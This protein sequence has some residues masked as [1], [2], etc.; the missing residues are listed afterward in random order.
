MKTFLVLLLAAKLYG[1][2]SVDYISTFYYE[3]SVTIS[4]ENWKK[5]DLSVTITSIGG[6]IIFNDRLDTRK[7]DG[8]KYNLR[9]LDSG[10]YEIVLEN[11]DKKVVETVI[12]F[13]GK[14]AEK[15]AQVYYKPVI[16][17]VDNKLKVNFLSFDGSASIK[18]YDEAL[19]VY[20]ERFENANPM[21]K[22]FDL[23]RLEPGKYTAV[24]GDG[25]TSR[26]VEF[27]K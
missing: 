27:E 13:D 8:I 9:N 11:N 18:I 3:P 10:K 21:N 26:T 16:E 12:L 17:M 23:S 20:A 1:N 2:V 4:F 14:I 25:Y 24:V 6:Q 22:V 19:T 15:E 7:A 5:G